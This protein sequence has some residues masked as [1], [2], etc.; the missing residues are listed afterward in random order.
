MTRTFA[1]LAGGLLLGAAVTLLVLRQP[2]APEPV[3]RDIVDVPK[4]TVA[5]AERHRDTQFA[6]IT[7]IRDVLALPSEFAQSEAL[8]AL[9][10]RSDAAAL[11]GLIFDANRIADDVVREQALSV[12]FYRLAE[13]DPQSAL[14]LARTEYFRGLKALERT[15]WRAWARKN[16]E[17]ALL[18]AKMQTSGRDQN[19]ATQSLYG[20]FGYMGNET[21]DHIEAELGIGPDR[22][23]RARFLYAMADRSP[24]EAIR[25]VESLPRGT[26]RGEYLSWLAYYL[27]QFDPAN[28]K[29]HANLFE[30]KTM[31]DGF[32]TVVASNAARSDPGA[33]ID[34]ILAAGNIRENQ[35]EFLS[36]MRVLA[37][38]DLDQALQY[39]QQVESTTERQW[40][41][42]IIVGEMVDENPAEALAWARSNTR[43]DMASLEMSV[44]I[45]L[46]RRDPQLAI[47]E[48]Q[49]SSNVNRRDD[50]VSNVIGQIA[51]DDPADAVRYLE[52]VTAHGQRRQAEQQIVSQWMRSDPDAALE[53]VLGNDDATAERLLTSSA[54]TLV[55]NDIDAAVRIL[56][57]ISGPQQQS[58]RMQIAQRMAVE[59]SPADAQAFV[60]QFE[61][62]PGYQH[63]QSSV[64]EGV[65]QSD[66]MLARQMADQLTDPQ[67]RDAAYSRIVAQFVQDDP[68]T[69]AAMVASITDERYRANAT[70]QVATG[71]YN[72]EP[73]AA[74]R[75]VA[76]LPPGSQRDDAVMHLAGQWREVTRE[77]QA[78]ID[79]ITDSD[80]RGQAKLRQVYNLMRTD[81]VRA[82]ELLE[83][84][85]IPSH[86][87]QQVELN[88]K[89][90]SI[91]Y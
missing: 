18:A 78:M 54:W 71:W 10:G 57:R 11:Q 51:R 35:N 24:A 37:S 50:L 72:V 87:R 59:R 6:E 75:W 25:F 80:K 70:A 82:R 17:D 49:R 2:P 48:A 42:S 47:A 86:A 83:D 63:L 84:P 20:A 30:D 33:T 88:L 45:Q 46:A 91:A 34:R 26:E 56:P 22:S 29:A 16:L 1:A 27:S 40:I 89:N 65:A 76:A 12:L 53:W 7:T 79:S 61:S 90:F 32:R 68:R 38:E 9:A 69:A 5:V 14:A 19:V 21:T 85:D 64:I 62:E 55:R 23:T 15:V 66:R 43:G 81:P 67:A 13:T 4:M 41:G 73:D 28:A 31:R 74:T 60:R 36:A 44:L 52:L 3:V 39:F 8:Y 58:M 77:Q